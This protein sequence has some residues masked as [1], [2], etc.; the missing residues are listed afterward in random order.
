MSFETLTAEI[1]AL[2]LEKRRE[3]M[4]F[5]IKLE[6]LEEPGISPEDEQR[7]LLSLDEAT[8]DVDSGKG[9]SIDEARQRVSSWA[10]K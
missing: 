8:R 6:A 3:L 10:A 1:S 9:V 7:L 4:Q 5:M 2:P